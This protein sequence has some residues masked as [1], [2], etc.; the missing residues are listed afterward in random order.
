M[1]TQTTRGTIKK[2]WVISGILLLIP[3]IVSV[4]TVWPMYYEYDLPGDIVPVEEVGI[5]GSVYFTY[6]QTGI[7]TNFYEKLLVEYNYG[8]VR[9]TP[10]D[11]DYARAELE[12]G[13]EP[14][15]HTETLD[16][17]VNEVQK[18]TDEY[19]WDFLSDR[20]YD[21]LEQTQDLYGE[22]FGMM[23]AIG[24]YE[25]QTGTDFSRRG[26]YKIAGTGTLE[27][28][29][30]IGSIGAM[31]EK[32]LTAAENNVDIFLV[33][34]DRDR[35][36]WEGM[37]NQDEALQTVEEEGIKMRVVPVDHLRDAILFLKFGL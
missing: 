10:I 31:R 16:Y 21:V 20:F 6:V 2:E 15:D 12:M 19:E 9:F 37:S 17:V 34:K 25:D 13:E 18:L 23:L 35:Y 11:N 7:T 36:Y 8:N 5:D 26:K 32:I 3:F 14:A 22:S 24:L 30:T 27:P 33:P 29:G 28:D 1:Q 4:I